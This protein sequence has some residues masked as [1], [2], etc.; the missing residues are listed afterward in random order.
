MMHSPAPQSHQSQAFQDD[1]LVFG[2]AHHLLDGAEVPVF[3]EPRSWPGDCIRRPS[4][5]PK[6]M[7]TVYFPVD[8]P[9][10]NLQLREVAFALLNPTHRSLRRASVFLLAE[11]PALNTVNQVCR[12]LNTVMRWA[13][14]NERHSD[15]GQWG[16]DGWQEFL[17]EQ[18]QECSGAVIRHFVHAIRRLVGVAA[19]VTG[20]SEFSDPWKGES[21]AEVA[22]KTVGFAEKSREELATPSIPPSTWWPLMRAAWAYIHTFGPDVLDLRDRLAKQPQATRGERNPQT[23]TT[24]ELDRKVRQWLADSANAVPV[25]EREWRGIPAGTPMWTT[26]SQLISDGASSC[27]FGRGNHVNGRQ[28]ARREMVAEAAAEGRVRPVV[29]W[30]GISV[31][32]G[33]AY[34]PRSHRPDGRTAEQLDAALARWLADPDN[35]VPVRARD[36]ARGDAGTPVYGTLARH[37]FQRAKSDLFGNSATGQRRRRM[38]AAAVAEG[39]VTSVA[40]EA[41][42]RYLTLPCPSFALVT[43]LDGEQRPWRS[44]ITR[45]ELDDELRMVRAACYVF[46]AGL[47][48]MRDSELQEIE[49]GA[50]TTYFGSPAIVSR[51]IKNDPSQPELFWWII[52]PVA[53]ALAI[54]ERLSWHESHVFA[55]LRPPA[56][57]QQTGRRGIEAAQDIDFFIEHINTGRDRT[58]L[59]EIPPARVRPHMFRKTMSLITGREPDSEIALGL[60]LKHAARRALA[61]RTTVNYGQM[62]ATW[63]KEFDHELEWA[64]ARRMVE[65]L[66]A[67]QSGESVAVGP[68]AA[69]LHARL[70]KVID[71]V[72]T[73]GH[74]RGQIADEQV[75]ATLLHA[76]FPDLHLGTLNHCMWDAAQAECQNALPADQRGKAPLIGACQ[77]AR[78]RNSAVTR[79]H[80][81]IWLAEEEDLTAIAK[82]RR[83][84]PPRRKAVLIRLADVR[85]VTRVFKDQKDE[86]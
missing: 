63:V 21:A 85:R 30:D 25:H 76:E 77:P 22:R 50:L 55:T 43:G 70:D 14:D 16:P 83:L 32:D 69:R 82:D 12:S 29:G 81:P 46:A 44:T 65:L 53:E 57:S 52:E 74:L 6:A 62:D 2:T 68:G 33:R 8:D 27:L 60:Q 72:V 49:R 39:R 56:G 19:I 48:L 75:Q 71:T 54:A 64:A 38:V 80:A 40:G 78:C 35:K 47:S 15:L 37:V 5:R 59:T 9:L 36:D 86:I 20:L 51:K 1:E 3:G 18:A 66:K 13:E 11:P 28:R 67:R 10:R 79:S 24:D 84:A 31:T 17:D 4:N 42:H 58:G 7:W 45:R 61:N 23:A 73:E 34:A 41:N 26:L